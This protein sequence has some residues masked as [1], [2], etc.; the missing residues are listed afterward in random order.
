MTDCTGS[1]SRSNIRLIGADGAGIFHLHG[2]GAGEEGATLVEGGFGELIESNIKVLERTP[3]R[4]DG[5]ILRAVKTEVLTFTIE[6]S[7]NGRHVNQELLQVDGP[8]RE[9]LTFEVDRWDPD[10]RLARIEWE[11]DDDLRW[12]EVVLSSMSYEITIDPHRRG[13][14]IWKV[15]LKAY[16]P[17]WK[18]RAVPKGVV[19]TEPGIKQVEISNP[20]SLPMYHQFSGT[21]AQWRLPDN[22]W[23][24]PR[25]KR[26]PGGRYPNRKILYPALTE[27]NGG[28]VVDYTPGEIKVR[29]KA[30]TNLIATMPTPG[31]YPQFCIPPFTQ[32]QTI[33]IE[34]VQV[35]PGGAAIKLIQPR[36]YRR[37]W[38]RV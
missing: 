12:V 7:V 9:A 34:A 2:D 23:Q 5:A 31:D 6:L 18:A 37:P 24:G 17:F 35:P 29:D 10:S 38:G 33:D 27:L 14:W 36:R 11:T 28:L 25:W 8:L 13:W 16:E 22:T 1:I 19:F 20:S 4:M 30:D 32:R 26:A 3:V 15:T 21:V